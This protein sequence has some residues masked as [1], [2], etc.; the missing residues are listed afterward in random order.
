MGLILALGSAGSLAE[1]VKIFDKSRS[2]IR[3]IQLRVMPF[4]VSEGFSVTV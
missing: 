1:A 2:R 3:N 4:L